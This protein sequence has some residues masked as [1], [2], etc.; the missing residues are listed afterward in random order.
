MVQT[1][2]ASVIVAAAAGYL[3][4]RGLRLLR[5]RKAGCSGGCACPTPAAPPSGN[6]IA[7]ETSRVHRR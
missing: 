2:L 1:A 3:L 7:L 4:W 5:G 6:L